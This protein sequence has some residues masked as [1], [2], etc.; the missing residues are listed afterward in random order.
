MSSGK[1]KELKLLL[2]ALPEKLPISDHESRLNRLLGFT[3]DEEKVE[4]GGR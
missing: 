3:L 1:F 4:G 2:K